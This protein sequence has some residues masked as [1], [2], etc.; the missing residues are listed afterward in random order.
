MLKFA[1]F[2]GVVLEGKAESP[3]WISIIDGDAEVR[4]ASHLWGLDTY[5]TQKVIY[6]ELSHSTGFGSWVDTKNGRQTTQRPCVLAIGP[7]G[8][9]RSRI[10]SILTD[11][12]AALGRGDLVGCGEPRI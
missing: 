6:R 8:E 1:G 5:T 4:D 2:D 9:N 10:A 7:A 12:E 11:T 3:V